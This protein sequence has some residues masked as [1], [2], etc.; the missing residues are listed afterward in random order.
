MRIQEVFEN[1]R[2]YHD[3]VSPRQSVA[4]RK[5]DRAFRCSRQNR[6]AIV[7]RSTKDS[8]RQGVTAWSREVASIEQNMFKTKVKGVEQMTRRLVS[9]GAVGLLAAAIAGSVAA[10]PMKADPR[11][12]VAGPAHCDRQNCAYVLTG[13]DAPENNIVRSGSYNGAL[14]LAGNLCWRTG[15]WTPA[16]AIAACDPDLVAKAAPVPVAAPAPQP[17]P[18]PAPAAPAAAPQVQKITLASKALFDFD[19]AVLKPEGKAAIDSEIIGKL[20]SVQK[21][22]L[23][24]VTGHTDRIGTQRYNQKLSERRADAVRDYL[25]SKGVPR[26]KIETLGMGKTQP[27]PGIVCNQKAL[28]ALIA[29]LAPDR[30]VEVEVKGEGTMRR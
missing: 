25:V 11:G 7:G 10:Q 24:L 13:Y 1:T 29:C 3:V 5:S 14:G 9:G 23:V 30:R 19:K 21:L 15:Y 28:K 16:M 8:A 27:L 12:Y 20:S 4:A 26:D 22:E 2:F 6:H 17:A 18:A